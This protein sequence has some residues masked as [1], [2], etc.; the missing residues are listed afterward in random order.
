MSHLTTD[1]PSL[2]AGYLTWGF[3]THLVVDAGWFVPGCAQILLADAGECSM[4]GR[5]NPNFYRFCCARFYYSY[6]SGV[7]R[8]LTTEYVALETLCVDTILIPYRYDYQIQF[9]GH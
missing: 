7:L 6:I 8:R 4:L 1:L 3:H 5:Q 9:N 2:N